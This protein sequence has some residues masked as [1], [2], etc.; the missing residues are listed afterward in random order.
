MASRF[1]SRPMVV[2]RAARSGRGRNAAAGGRDA[3]VA[4]LEA[5][6]GLLEVLRGLR[7]LDADEARD[8]VAHVV[9]EAV[10][11][12]AHALRRLGA[13][14]LELAQP[15]AGLVRR[16]VGAEDDLVARQLLGELDDARLE[17]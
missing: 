12:E 10:L 16:R 5:A 11:V 8:V 15:H 7:G 9:L 14:H 6:L 2:A 17:R 3:P 13:Q 4:V 1:I